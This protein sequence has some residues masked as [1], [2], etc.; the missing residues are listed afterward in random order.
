MTYVDGNNQDV[1]N[2]TAVITGIAKQ[3]LSNINKGGETVI[4]NLAKKSIDMENGKN[5]KV[6]NREING[7]KTFKVDVE[8][9]LTTLH[10]SQTKLAM[11]RLYSVVTKLLT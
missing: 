6:S 7:V 11:A 9:D 4:Q 2:E 10:P 1:P 5:T 8:G 3:D